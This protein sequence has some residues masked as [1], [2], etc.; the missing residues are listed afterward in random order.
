MKTNRLPEDL[1]VIAFDADDTLW[2]NEQFFAEAEQKFL[3]MLEDFLPRHSV[4]RELL[5]TEIGRAH[6]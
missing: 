2:E 3:A 5:H 1:A 4:A 6:V